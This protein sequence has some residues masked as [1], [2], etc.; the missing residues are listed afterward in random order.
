MGNPR[1]VRATARGEARR[2]E[3]GV[4]SG[5]QPHYSRNAKLEKRTHSAAGG[6]GA[7]VIR[8]RSARQ[9]GAKHGEGRRAWLRAPQ[10]P[11]PLI[12]KRT[13]SLGVGTP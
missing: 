12:Y 10:P 11:L 6:G 2:R 3:E 5:R 7:W 8:A 13:P 9:H 4:A 1:E